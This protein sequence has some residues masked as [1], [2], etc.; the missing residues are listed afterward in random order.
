MGLLD[1][2]KHSH[3]SSQGKDYLKP[4]IVADENEN[5]AAELNDASSPRKLEVANV[6]ELGTVHSVSSYVNRDLGYQGQLSNH[7]LLTYGDTMW[8]DE[9]YSP[10]F[11]GMTCN[12]V[13]LATDN[14]L[15]VLDTKKGS[16]GYPEAALPPNAAEGEEHHEYACG[17]T[18]IIE[19]APGE[20]EL[21]DLLRFLKLIL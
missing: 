6:T 16:H 20:G 21:P 2:L 19:V 15:H 1:K 10:E 8:S 12:S 11:R 13:A 5:E 4:L 18:N 14:V 7:I 9:N 3:K 17:I